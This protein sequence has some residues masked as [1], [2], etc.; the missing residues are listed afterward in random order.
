MTQELDTI[1]EKL[2]SEEAFVAFFTK[3]KGIGSKWIGDK[4]DDSSSCISYE[5]ADLCST[6]SEKRAE[7]N[8]IINLYLNGEIIAYRVDTLCWDITSLLTRNLSDALWVH[9]N[10]IVT[11]NGKACVLME[12]P[13]AEFKALVNHFHLKSI[14]FEGGKEVQLSNMS[15]YMPRL[16]KHFFGEGVVESHYNVDSTISPSIVET[17]HSNR[18]D[19]GSTILSSKVE[20]EKITKWLTS[21]G[22]TSRPKLLY[23]A[24]RDGWRVSDFHR[25]CDGK[26]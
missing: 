4:L 25:M 9:D 18:H 13:G 6:D 8:G 5:S 23:R 19:M 12:Y 22:K 24:S 26:G 16:I 21:A 10:T 3:A 20:E 14:T 11:E 17:A 15:D 7:E 1:E 2:E